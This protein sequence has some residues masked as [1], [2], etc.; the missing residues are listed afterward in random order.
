MAFQTF[1]RFP[2]LIDVHLYSE[3]EN[4]AGQIV[5]AF[6]F[7]DTIRGAAAPSGTSSKTAPYVNDSDEYDIHIPKQFE[8]KVT[9]G[10]RFHNIRDAHGNVL[11]SGP[12]EVL[13]ILK[14]PSY[15]GKVHHLIVI[16]RVVMEAKSDV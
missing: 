15:S 1:L 5:P 4:A 8:S 13:S 7:S 6:Y 3:A 2:H 11:E 10:A 16:A 12:L 9:Y 14:H